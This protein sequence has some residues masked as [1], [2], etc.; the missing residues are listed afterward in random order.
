MSSHVISCHVMS[1]RGPRGEGKKRE[2]WGSAVG[3]NK[4]GFKVVD[5]M[6]IFPFFFFFFFFFFTM[7]MT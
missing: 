3:V 4:G 7:T 1:W 6:L 2:I 5:V